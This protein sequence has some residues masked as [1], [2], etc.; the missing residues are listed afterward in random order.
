[1][2]ALPAFQITRCSI[3]LTS[4]IKIL[5]SLPVFTNFDINSVAIRFGLY[6]ISRVWY[7]SNTIMSITNGKYFRGSSTSLFYCHDA[8][9]MFKV[10]IFT[11]ID[12]IYIVTIYFFFKICCIC[13]VS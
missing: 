3:S 1:M 12:S 2:K 8:G 11:C 4:L 6:V 10:C 9:F 5:C 13:M 7:I